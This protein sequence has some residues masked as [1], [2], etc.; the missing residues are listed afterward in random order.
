MTFYDILYICY[1]CQF[2][3]Y[4][5]MLKFELIDKFILMK[6]ANFPLCNESNK[7]DRSVRPE[8]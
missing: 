2:S 7:S 4:L 3:F 5:V 1:L 6:H 8:K